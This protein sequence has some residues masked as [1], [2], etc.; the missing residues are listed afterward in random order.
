[1][2]TELPPEDND[3]GPLLW[4][5]SSEGLGGFDPKQRAG[6]DLQNRLHNR[7][8]QSAGQM[9][10]ISELAGSMRTPRIA[11]YAAG[12]ALHRRGLVWAMTSVGDGERVK[13]FAYREPP[14]AR[15]SGP[16]QREEDHE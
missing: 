6:S 2:N 8:R 5:G 4:L 16:Q 12:M 15:L 10:S 3:S 13:T 11:I 7:L 1:M 9:F 14:N